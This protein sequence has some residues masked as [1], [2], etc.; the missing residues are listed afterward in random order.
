MKAYLNINRDMG[1]HLWEGL[2]QV[3][4]T[5]CILNIREESFFS[6]YFFSVVFSSHWSADCIR[7]VI[8]NGFR[9]KEVL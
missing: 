7:T 3:G 6:L 5:C 1:L 9:E 8:E 4:S 2:K